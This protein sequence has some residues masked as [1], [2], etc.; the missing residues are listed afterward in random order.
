MTLAEQARADT[1][2]AREKGTVHNHVVQT[3][4]EA[5]LVELKEATKK[6]CWGCQMSFQVEYASIADAFRLRLHLEGFAVTTHSHTLR[7]L[8]DTQSRSSKYFYYL[9]IDWGN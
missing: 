2:A 5:F 7:T 9:Y 1:A 3:L 4:W 8:D 6:K